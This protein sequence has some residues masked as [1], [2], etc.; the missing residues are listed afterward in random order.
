MS[1]NVR[2]GGGAYAFFFLVGDAGASS[3]MVGVTLRFLGFSFLVLVLLSTLVFKIEPLDGILGKLRVLS[4]VDFFMID[5]VSFLSA[6]IR[7][8]ASLTDKILPVV[9]FSSLMRL[10]ISA[11]FYLSTIALALNASNRLD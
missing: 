1:S 9:C 6:S 4:I 5:L 3:A 8:F 11:R 2:V 10:Y 7:S